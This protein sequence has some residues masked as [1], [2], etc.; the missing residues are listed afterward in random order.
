MQVNGDKNRIGKIDNSDIFCYTNDNIS[1]GIEFID[2]VDNLI[3]DVFENY[4]KLEDDNTN[5]GYVILNQ[6]PPSDLYYH[7]VQGILTLKQIKE[8]INSLNGFYRG[9]KNSRGLIGATASIAWNHNLDRTYELITYRY[10]DKW[11]SNRYIDDESVKKIDKLYPSTFDNYDYDNKHNRRI[12]WC[13]PGVSD[14][15]FL[16][17]QEDFHTEGRN[18]NPENLLSF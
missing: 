13:K 2:R 12:D 17:F 8:I 18:E 16:F 5:P 1:S 7:G 14:G 3:N 15:L 4:A 6:K 9:Y 11:G 10:K